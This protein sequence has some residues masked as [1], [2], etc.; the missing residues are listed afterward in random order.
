MAIDETCHAE[1]DG[2]LNPEDAEFGEHLADGGA[3]RVHADE[4]AH[5]ESTGEQP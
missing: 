5:A 4:G 3:H 1:I 2:G